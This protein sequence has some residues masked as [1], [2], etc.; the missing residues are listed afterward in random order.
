M[1]SPMPNSLSRTIL[2]LLLV[3]GVSVTFSSSAMAQQKPLP[4][5]EPVKPEKNPPGDIPD[6]QVFIDYASP[7]GFS[8]KV[9]E[10]WARQDLPDGVSFADK[11]GRISMSQTAAQ[12]MLSVEEAKQTLVPKLERSSR[13]VTVAAVKP[14]KLPAGPAIRISY[15]SNSDPNP[16]TNKA[17]RLENDRYY[18]W[19]DGKLVTVNFS[20]PAGADNADQW[21]MMA[22]SFR[23][24]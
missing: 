11:Y 16:V 21:D 1:E 6:N 13:A 2:I 14:V 18:F 23:W 15:S 7:L 20:A 4:A 17:I 5:A 22:R 8:V 12:K 24:R 3:I 19:K 9:P 10:G